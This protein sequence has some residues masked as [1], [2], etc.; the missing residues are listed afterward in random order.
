MGLNGLC[1][2]N[3]FELELWSVLADPEVHPDIDTR[4]DP[5]KA[6]VPTSLIGDAIPGPQV[7]ERLMGEKRLF[8]FAGDVVVAR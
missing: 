3:P 4:D 7:T 5:V 8:D 6:G 2:A 1:V